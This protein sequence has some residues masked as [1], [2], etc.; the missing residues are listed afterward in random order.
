MIKSVVKLLSLLAFM[1]GCMDKVNVG[2]FIHCE[3]LLHDMSIF[4]VSAVGICPHMCMNRET[5]E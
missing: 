2:P 4:P 1:D 3:A 5:G